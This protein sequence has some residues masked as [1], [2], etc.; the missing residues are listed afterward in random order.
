MSGRDEDAYA[1]V[2]EQLRVRGVAGLCVPRCLWLELQLRAVSI[3][4]TVWRLCAD[5]LLMPQS[6]Q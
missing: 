5:M 2:D 6:C 1:V 4:L 3:E